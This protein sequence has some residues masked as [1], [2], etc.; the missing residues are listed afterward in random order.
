MLLT[1][2]LNYMD[3]TV[4]SILVGPLEQAF[5]ISDT[6]MGILQ[7]AAFA[8]F[9]VLFGF[10]LARLADRSN[11]RNLLLVGSMIWCVAT[12]YA[13]LARS[14]QELF[15]ARIVVAIGESVVMPCAVSILADYYPPLQRAKALSVY[16]VGIYL[17]SALA[18]GGGGVL[19]RR[20]GSSSLALPILGTLQPWRVVFVACGVLGFVIV[21]LLFTV[22]EPARL[23]DDGGDAEAP[24]SLGQVA[25]EFRRKRKAILGTIV[26]F[27][28]IALAGSTIQAWGPTLFVRTHGWTIGSAGLRLGL[29]TLFFGPAGAIAGGVLADRLAARGHVDAKL[30]VG[31]VSALAGVVAGIVL[32]LESDG[33]AQIGAASL[34][35]LVGFNFGITQAAL[36]DLMPNRMRALTS[37]LYISMTN[38]FSATLGPL[39]VGILN[40]HVFHDPSRIALSMR[41]IVPLAFAGAAGV[42][43]WGRSAV[44]EVVARADE[45]R[46]QGVA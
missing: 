26:G 6:V 17:G 45:L 41:L 32:T 16:S 15:A 23:R 8:V 31:L 27:A 20:L 11:R 9:Y 25:V 39:T 2:A 40:D 44:R 18:L 3:R 19:L 4:I 37:A 7:G 43:S 30:I 5:A 29:M 14:V 28:L 34:S 38:L 46:S 1:F 36:A 42:L 10:P 21:P 13:G 35:C 24:P 22:R 33:A 12:A